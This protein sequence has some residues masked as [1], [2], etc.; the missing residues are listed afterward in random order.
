[1]V[2]PRARFEE[3]NGDLYING[4]QVIKG[5][6]SW[7]GLYWFA[8]ENSGKQDSVID[9]QVYAN[10]TI[11]FGYVQG[12][13]DEWGYFSQAELDLLRPLIWE[14]RKID[15]PYAGRR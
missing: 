15:L 2:L 11:Y 14:I 7:N 6:E 9:G 4:E 8:V 12:N 10:D 13:E 5:W 1:M 3:R